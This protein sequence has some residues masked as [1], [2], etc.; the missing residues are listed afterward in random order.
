[1]YRQQNIHY[2]SIEKMNEH[3]AYVSKNYILIKGK[4]S[5]SSIKRKAYYEDNEVNFSLTYKKGTKVQTYRCRKDGDEKH[6]L[7]LGIQAFKIVKQY[8]G[9]NCL[10]L[11]NNKV[12]FKA[13]K[14]QLG[15]NEEHSR[16]I[17]SARPILYK[18][19]KYENTRNV[20]YSYD[21]N[22]AYSN[23]MIQSMPDTSKN[24]RMNDIIRSEN[25]LGFYTDGSELIC[26]EEI[27]KRCEW[28][29]EK[30]ESPF[31]RFVE[32]WYNRKKK[33]NKNS[34]EREKA[35]QILN[36]SVGYFQKV[37]P[38][39]R[40]RIISYANKVIKDLINDQTIYC[41]T[42]SIVSLIKREDI[43]VGDNIGDFKLE[44]KGTYFAFNGFNYQ[45]D[46]E[47]PT[48]RGVAKTWFPQGYDILKDPLPTQG[49]RVKFN[50]KSGMLE[51]VIYEKAR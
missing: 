36:Y 21:V 16:F 29:F 4:V 33:A 3:L 48:Y 40:A 22:S 18:N 15:W 6:Q 28:I 41:N 7:I 8:T 49:N 13:W 11:R 26:T 20:A 2:I 37:N 5:L 10:D 12:R 30:I 24:P 45:W 51:E 25:E 31:K 34:A 17:A 46:Y 27:G 9:K 14:V 39:V 23:G 47:V 32:V 50:P 1:M 19:D 38:F 42:D 35:K 43:I 44:D